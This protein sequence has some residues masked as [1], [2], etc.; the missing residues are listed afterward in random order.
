MRIL[1]S[2]RV[3]TPGLEAR[4]CTENT[5]L[6]NISATGALVRSEVSLAE[7]LECPFILRARDELVRLMVRVVWAKPLRVENADPNTNT[8]DE[9]YLVAVRFTH[10]PPLAKAAVSALRG[11]YEWKE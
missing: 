2:K 10:L 7:G 3:R 11:G 9:Q 8:D 5:H 1:R 6:V 4:V